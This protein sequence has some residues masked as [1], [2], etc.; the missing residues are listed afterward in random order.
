MPARYEVIDGVLHAVITGTYGAQEAFALRGEMAAMVRE[1]NL[2]LGIID[3][4][5]ADITHTTIDIY[6]VN[7]SL[8]DFIPKN[9]RFAFVY[10]PE[11]LPQEL[12]A[13][14]EDVLVNAGYDARVC[15]DFDD[16]LQ[17]IKEGA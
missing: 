16:A 17:W 5:K 13:F 3:L 8:D 9:T 11:N 15:T 14:S 1:Q 7:T 4:R 6:E 2:R 12:A 10:A